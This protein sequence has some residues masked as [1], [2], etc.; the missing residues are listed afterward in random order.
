M[1]KKNGFECVD[2]GL[3]VKWASCNVGA[4]RPEDFGDYYAW[5]ETDPKSIYHISNYKWREFW[6]MKITKYNNNSEYGPIDNKFTLDMEDDVAHVKWG[7]NWRMATLDEWGELFENCTWKWYDEGN[8]EFG[9][10]AGYKIISKKEG[11]SG[12]YIFLPAAG[13]C[14]SRDIDEPGRPED[15]GKRGCYWTS[16]LDEENSG[17]ACDITFI[18]EYGCNSDRSRIFG[19]SVRP[20]CP[21][22]H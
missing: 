6:P 2:L 12:R 11:F 22:V 4:Q 1:E 19:H 15:I 5:G 9:G 8:S 18:S 17:S 20:V 3:S 21:K 10:V 7:G 14:Y 13:S 16:S